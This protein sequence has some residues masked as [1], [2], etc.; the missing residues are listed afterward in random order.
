MLTSAEVVSCA[1][2][3]L[4]ECVDVDTV[5]RRA[6]KR[7]E[8]LVG[9]GKQRARTGCVPTQRVCDADR[10]LSQAA[11]QLAPFAGRRLPH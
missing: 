5:W 8:R 7:V 11:P 1:A 6:G 3:P 2:S 4:S 9:P 10:K